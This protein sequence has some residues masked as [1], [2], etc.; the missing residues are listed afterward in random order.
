MTSALLSSSQLSCVTAAGVGANL[1]WSMV[2]GSQTASTPNGAVLSSYG[3]PVVSS[4]SGVG[5]SNAATVGNQVRRPCR[6]CMLRWSV[7]FA[8]DVTS[9]T[10]LVRCYDCDCISWLLIVLL[11]FV[12]CVCQVVTIIGLNFGPLGTPVN[13]LYTTSDLLR[14]IVNASSAIVSARSGSNGMSCAPFVRGVCRAL[15]VLI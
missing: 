5:S 15:I 8:I 7:Y 10:M 12:C 11:V 13:A 4:F 14:S 6:D 9:R 3:R 2:I 1:V